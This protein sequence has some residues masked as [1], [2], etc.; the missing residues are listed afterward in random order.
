ML[1]VLGAKKT[2]IY[3]AADPPHRYFWYTKYP[4]NGVNNCPNL[5]NDQGSA[6]VQHH[7]TLFW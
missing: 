5:G 2:K 4:I 3:K 7:M 6:S 1:N